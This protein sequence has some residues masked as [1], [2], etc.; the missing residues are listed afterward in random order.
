MLE[1]LWPMHLTTL[2]RILSLI[3][4]VSAAE[5][6]F[7]ADELLDENKTRA[8]FLEPGSV[9]KLT[10]Q[11]KPSIVTVRQLGRDGDN[12]GIGSGFVIDDSGLIATNFH[13]IGEGRPVEVEFS[14]GKVFPVVE[15]NAW[16]RNFDLAVLRIEPGDRKLAAL[17]VGDSATVEQGQIIIG[18]GAPL[19][20]KFSVV[21]GVVSAI[22]KLDEEFLGEDTPDFPMI[23]VAMPIESGNSGGPIVNLAGEVMGVISL[24]HR[25]KEN[26]G[27][28]IRSS[29]L[30]AIVSRPNPVPMA[31]WKT[32][33]SLDPKQWTVLMDGDWNQRGGAILAKNPGKGFG[34]RTLCLSE[35]EIPDGAFEIAVKV[36]LDDEAGAAG[37]A[38]SSDGGDRHY[39]FYP[40]GGQI[41]LTRFDGPDVYSWNILKQLPFDAYQLGEWNRLRV[42][43]DGDSIIGFVN[44]EEAVNLIDNGIKGGKAGLC[45][46]RQTEAKFRDFRIGQDLRELK[47]SSEEIERL[48]AQI[49]QFLSDE[50]ETRLMEVL[51]SGSSASG[52][53][54]EL[55]AS[56]YEALALQMRELK[57]GLHH[58]Q[59]AKELKESIDA[60]EGEAIDLFEVALQIA[61]IDDPELDTQHYRTKFSRLVKEAKIFINEEKGIVGIRKLRD[62][63]FKEN[64]FHG[65][66]TEYYHHSNS[67]INHVLDDREGLPITLSVVFIEMARRLDLKQVYGV[68]LPG[69]FLVGCKDTGDK[70]FLFD[71]FEDGREIT[72]R[73]A[74]IIAAGYRSGTSDQTF[75]PSLPAEI[76]M[77]MLRNLIS[78]EIEEEKNPP[79]AIGYLNL[80]LEIDPD[81]V[82]ERFQRALISAQTGKNKLA[83]KDLDW[84][85]KKGPSGINIG[86]LTKFRDS[87][88]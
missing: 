51:S 16:D 18:Y 84:L 43:I 32:I 28:A 47:L 1:Q 14:D 41:R 75:E 48:D 66:R 79:A 12:F 70:L 34:G 77:R 33:G 78:I 50:D 17:E 44:G 24:R 83:I 73:D 63:L 19:G 13:V 86:R 40:S 87:L 6:S 9:Q 60:G 30:S 74:E 56:Q 59:V 61:R 82:Q 35:T 42:R 49:D 81:S 64:G 11:V 27:F 62:F 72:R 55:K 31:R 69:R 65:N 38:F 54:L 15:I 52:E 76:A 2:F 67:Y 23:Q 85:I 29:E 88:R 46:F 20:L 25:L 7:C 58:K 22:R 21:S 5:F 39:G 10:N 26:L 80:L 53:F 57:A 37:L 8:K 3:Y 68:A 4:F 45:K 36:K 71:V